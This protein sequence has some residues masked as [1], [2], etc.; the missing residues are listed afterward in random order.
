MKPKSLIRILTIIHASLSLGLVIFAGFAYLQNGSFSATNNAD[1]LFIY[2]VPVIAMAGYFGSKFVYQNLIRNLPKE[3]SLSK[4]MQRYQIANIF[5]FALLEGPAFLA[6]GI[7]YI[8]GNALH[9]VIGLSLLV[10]LFFQRPSF[11]KLKSELPLSLE[12][13]KE[14]DI[15]I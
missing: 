2:V 5:K 9:L 14:F 12:E 13:E 15:L 10:Y 8:S 3:E 11:E 6:L 4:K 1:D 7:Y